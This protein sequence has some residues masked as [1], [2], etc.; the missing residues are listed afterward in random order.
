MLDF[1]IKCLRASHADFRH[2]LRHTN[3]HYGG[4]PLSLRNGEFVA[5]LKSPLLQKPSD[6]HISFV[7]V[8]PHLAR[9]PLV[10]LRLDVAAGKW[11]YVFEE[12]KTEE[13]CASYAHYVGG[14]FGLMIAHS[15]LADDPLAH[16]NAEVADVLAP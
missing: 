13:W 1:T 11:V 8:H 9:W 2:A 16:A 6:G 10:S 12:W 5:S 15:M 7:P 14:R 3:D 4:F